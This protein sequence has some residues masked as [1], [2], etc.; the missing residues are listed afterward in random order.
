M[1]REVYELA[2][3][4]KPFELE[5]VL[6]Q[7]LNEG[8]N[9]NE[10]LDDL[11]NALMFSYNMYKEGKFAL[12]HLSAM[13]AT[14][15]MGFEVLKKHLREYGGRG[16]IVMG[17]LGSIHYIGKDIIKCFYIG[18]GYKVIDLGENLLAID[19]IQAIQKYNPDLLALSIFL[20]N[21]IGELGKIIE[22][23]EKNELRDRVKVIIGGTVA[24]EHIAQKYRVDGWGRDPSS[25]VKLANDLIKR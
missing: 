7:R 22:Y 23:L 25:A 14:F 3:N 11:R 13:V 18:E 10:L 15:H 8:F 9:P 2:I 1:A 21:A 17:T 20:T 6:Q 5:K 24:N 4:F 19:V 16:T 12:P